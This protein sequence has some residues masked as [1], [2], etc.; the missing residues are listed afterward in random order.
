MTEDPEAER[1]PFV[2]EHSEPVAAPVDAVWTALLRVLLRAFG[3]AGSVARILACDPARATSEFAGRPGEAL[4][5]FRVVE[6]EPGRRL[7]LRGRHR[8]AHYTLTFVLDSQRLRATTHAAFPG[9]LGQ[10]Y[11]GAV[12][13]SGAHAIV[14]R[15]LLRRV[16]RTA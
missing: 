11:R 3:G 7:A 1:L 15:R 12:V 5:G 13:G 10:I 16:V 6:A 2:D 4:P 8:F 14:T 9:V